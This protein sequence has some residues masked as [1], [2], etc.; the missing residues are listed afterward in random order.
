M[1]KRKE[2]KK[3]RK[4]NQSNTVFG[5]EKTSHFK[6]N[7]L[8]YQM[9]AEKIQYI[10]GIHLQIEI[11]FENFLMQTLMPI[12]IFV[13]PKNF[14]SIAELT[15]YAKKIKTHAALLPTTNVFDV[16]CSYAM[17]CTRPA[18]TLELRLMVI[19]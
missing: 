11:D 13:R 4:I 17:L 16:R 18:L 15:R 7:A 12:D 5:V 6:D 10:F 1:K 14:T 19:I 3:K 2:K 8:H 9:L